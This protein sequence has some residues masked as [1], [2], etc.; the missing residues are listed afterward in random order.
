MKKL[1]VVLGVVAFGFAFTSCKKDCK[2]SITFDGQEVLAPTSVG[3]LSKSDCE[4][5]KYDMSLF[6]SSS[7]LTCK[8]E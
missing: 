6:D 8:S 7:K 3:E 4:A 2:C 1:F 5:Y